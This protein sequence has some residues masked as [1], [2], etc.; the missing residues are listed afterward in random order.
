[1]ESKYYEKPR[2]L[3]VGKIINKTLF[4]AQVVLLGPSIAFFMFGLSLQSNNSNI[5]LNNTFLSGYFDLNT[6]AHTITIAICAVNAIV[7]ACCAT[8]GSSIP[9]GSVK[10]NTWLVSILLSA[11]KIIACISAIAAFFIVQS[12][13]RITLYILLYCKLILGA[14]DL[15]PWA[16]Y[17]QCVVI[18]STDIATISPPC[19]R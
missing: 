5:H 2:R 6:I 9:Y 16:S 19:P 12:L 18:A 14:R 13:L 7:V 11:R 17:I 3:V 10:N 1:M 8:E 4:V 15:P